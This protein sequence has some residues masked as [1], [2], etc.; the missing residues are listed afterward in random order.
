MRAARFV[1]PKPGPRKILR[2]LL[3]NEEVGGCWLPE[4]EDHLPIDLREFDPG[5]TAN[6]NASLF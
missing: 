1:M 4:N 5:N 2:D 6:P 3:R